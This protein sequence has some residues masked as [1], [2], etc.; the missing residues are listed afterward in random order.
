M[1]ES[2]A[3]ATIR[4]SVV[5]DAG[6]VDLAVP[7]WA[8]VGAVAAG[9]RDQ[10]GS[11]PVL[12]STATGRALDPTTSVHAA[13][14]EHGDLLVAVDA[15]AAPVSTAPTG[16]GSRGRRAQP[17]A[18]ATSTVAPLPALAPPTD[19][20]ARSATGSVVARLAPGAVAV[21]GLL[22]ATAGALT[23]GTAADAASGALA[24][25]V[26]AVA[27]IVGLR[28]P[29]GAHDRAWLSVVPLLL[30][31]A[32]VLQLPPGQAGATTLAVT[33][34]GLAVACGSAA[35]R[36]AVPGVA[37][38]ELAVQLVAGVGVAL[39][40]TVTLLADWSTTTLAAL[41]LLA[42]VL[43]ARL[44]PSFVVDV[45]DHVLV[46]LQR[47]AVTA[48]TA[49]EQPRRSFRGVVRE[50]DVRAV[51]LRALRLVGAATVVCSLLVAASGAW[52]LLAPTDGARDVGATL[53]CAAT[54]AA[55]VLSGR[56]L[57][58]Q[59]ARRWQRT[60]GTALLLAT[61][62]SLLL[63]VGDDARVAGATVAVL[64][65]LVLAL[66]ARSAGR[67]WTSVW[68]SRSAEIAEGL[69][70]VAVVGAFPLVSGLFDWMRVLTSS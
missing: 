42:A 15:D 62:A 36:A 40:A 27:G 47:L 37:D 5:G 7:R 18:P 48:W 50:D 6:R 56:T 49:R 51:A 17:A 44:L 23:G 70:F 13:R 16:R 28:V 32:V 67:G 39:L 53:V 46:D 33:V 52:L 26:L 9:F 66:V 41:V 31:A 1:S 68:W 54:G 63:E 60:T 24:L 35:L 11:G 8:D 38:E 61:A 2:T 43:G 45:P 57:R 19:R 29:A 59:Q 55:L 30:A 69:A 12:L 3:L 20:A 10:T 14:L 34:A 64:L 21:A 4:L 25:V 22:A 58:A 65:G